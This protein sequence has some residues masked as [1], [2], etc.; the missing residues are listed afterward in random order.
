MMFPVGGGEVYYDFDTSMSTIS[1]CRKR[2]RNKSSLSLSLS[3][4]LIFS[5]Y[6]LSYKTGIL[7]CCFDRI[8]WVGLNT[9][10]MIVEE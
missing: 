10:M 7:S 6:C 9:V 3:P 4:T 1:L 8:S 2:E 5:L